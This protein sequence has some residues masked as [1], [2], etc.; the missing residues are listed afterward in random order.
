MPTLDPRIDTYIAQAAPFAQP[1]LEHLRQVV[2]AACPDT[3]ETL[4]W[5][6]PSFM[7]RGAILAS[8]AAF[9]QHASFGV[10]T[11]ENTGTPDAGEGM[12]QYGKLTRKSELPTAAELKKAL[13]DGMV[14]VDARKSGAVPAKKRVLKAALPEPAA[15]AAALDATPTVRAAFDAMTPGVRREYVE[16]VSAAKRD[17]TRDARIATLL[18]QVGEGKSLHWKYKDC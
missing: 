4:K 7:Y 12:G 6:M 2:H 14:A 11:R 17:V 8:M 3:E 13:R 9:K 15:L 16:W 10:W 1:I 18:A 5:G